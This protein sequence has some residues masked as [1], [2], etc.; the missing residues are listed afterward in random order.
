KSGYH[1]GDLRRALLTEAVEVLSEGGPSAVTVYLG[2]DD[3]PRNLGVQGENY[4]IYAQEDH[5][6]VWHDAHKA[7]EGD[8]QL[9][10]LSFPSLKNPLAKAHTA[11][12]ITLVHHD[13]FSRW[14]DKPW[15]KRGEDYVAF[16]ERIADGL[17]ELANS[18]V[19]GLRDRIVLKEIST[20]VTV[21][22]FTAWPAGAFYGLPFTPKR[23]E[24]KWLGAHT[25]IKGLYMGG[26]DIASMGVMGALM[27]GFAATA[28]TLSPREL[29]HT[30]RAMQPATS[31]RTSHRI[32]TEEP[33]A[34]ATV[35]AEKPTEAQEEVPVVVPLN[36]AT[37]PAKPETRP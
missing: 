28:A 19:P 12:V 20:P 21:T 29:F 32:W 34:K 30:M 4:W 35:V 25:P 3:D 7:L 9:A 11:E 8:P 24:Q 15:M 10:Y 13:A 14:Q 16:K 2:L 27:G 37:G 31:G 22:D 33:A 1:H 23:M 36:G 5:D 6:Q 18:R 17:L 26:S